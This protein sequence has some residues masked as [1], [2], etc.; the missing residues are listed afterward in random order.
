MSYFL[1][2]AG[3]IKHNPSLLKLIKILLILLLTNYSQAQVL[4]VKNG[5][6]KDTS[7]QY[8]TSYVGGKIVGNELVFGTETGSEIKLSDNGSLSFAGG[9]TIK[10][11]LYFEE[12][13]NYS[14]F[15]K[16][17][18]ICTEFR[19]GKM[20][21]AWMSFPSEPIFTTNSTQFTYFPV[22]TELLNG[23]AQ[24]P[25][26]QW[27]SVEVNYDESIG[28]T[29][30]KINGVVDRV[31]TRYRGR[32]QIKNV[33][34]M[35]LRFLQNAQKVRVRE[36]SFKSGQP[37]ATPTMNVY[38][39]ALTYQNKL[40]LTFD[41]IDNR[42]PLPIPVTVSVSRPGQ[43]TS[44]FTMKLNNLNRKDTL[45][46]LPF[47]TGSLSNVKIKTSF[48]EENFEVANR[49]APSPFAGKFPIFMYNAQAEDYGQLA[50]MGFSVIKS[51]WS[52]LS[53]GKYPPG[54]IQRCLDSAQA[55]G[56]AITIAANS[57]PIK[58]DYVSK[59][60]S[61]PA[62]FGWYLADE[63]GGA[64]LLDTIRNY[65][66]AVKTVDQF[67]P[68]MVTM[69]NFNRLTGL[70]ND[71]MGVD[72]FPMPNVSLR[73]VSDAVKAGL[74]ATNG[75][76]PVVCFLPHY[77]GKTPNLEELK[78]MAWLSVIAGA[79][80]IGVFEWDH[81]SPFTPTGYYAGANPTHVY[82]LG[83]VF[84]EVRSWDWLLTAKTTLYDSGNIAVHASTKTAL[85]KTYLLVANDSRQAEV[86]LV[87]VGAKTVPLVMGPLEVRMI[88]MATVL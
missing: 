75:N 17:S 9:F 45:I 80:G 39:N 30:T 83:T 84:R 6:F 85:G 15:L 71:I 60:K 86:G 25:L 4:R 70:D 13:P 37:V 26:N 29:T 81:R 48:L 58:L 59:F 54:E 69:N 23:Y 40:L 1:A 8:T 46:P 5:V 73:M 38:A 68:T 12:V 27:V 74:A 18:S 51:D 31:L 7:N 14:F 79:W 53:S 65:N 24:L 56:I 20:T 3:R 87:K 78:C 21:N 52:V 2:T 44:T 10:G 49:N 32:E 28:V 66:I 36:L 72:P 57:G 55:N 47:W 33:S 50:D 64:D 63:P 41:Q 88:N 82:N 76:K 22:G 19:T 42:L 67:R 77:S 35:S 11:E 16:V 34:N 43:N 61:H 62:L